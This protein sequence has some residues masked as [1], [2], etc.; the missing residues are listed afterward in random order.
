MTQSRQPTD[1]CDQQQQEA[2]R[3]R[4]GHSSRPFQVLWLERE[5]V[6]KPH[7][8]DNR[9][10]SRRARRRLSARYGPTP[11]R[12]PSATV[13]IARPRVSAPPAP[14]PARARRETAERGPRLAEDSRRAESASERFSD[15]SGGGGASR[16]LRPWGSHLLYVVVSGG[17][18]PM[19]G[20]NPA[21]YRRPT[22]RKTAPSA[23]S[24]RRHGSWNAPS[25]KAE[26]F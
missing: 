25:A 21:P 2:R 3:F 12:A 23:V 13:A 20:A 19:G 10:A 24:V 22:R 26:R 4:S 16:L 14:A 18:T 5:G 15:A 11:G 17:E 7:G 1:P 9:A 6:G 8:G